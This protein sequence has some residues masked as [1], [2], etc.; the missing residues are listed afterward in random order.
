M[1]GSENVEFGSASWCD[2]NCVVRG[3]RV[4]RVT[5][6][7][8]DNT[9]PRKALRVPAEAARREHNKAVRSVLHKETLCVA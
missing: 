7:E 9:L 6:M 1:T 2:T 8:L 3:T 4:T 5:S